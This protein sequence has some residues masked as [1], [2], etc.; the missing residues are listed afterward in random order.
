[1]NRSKENYVEEFLKFKPELK[2]FVFRLMANRQDTEDI[3]HD[4]FLKMDK[5]LD[6]FKGESSFKTWVFSIATNTAK[7]LLKKKKRW[8]ENAPDY[9]AN[10]HLK[11]S[12]H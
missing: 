9:G 1:M 10:L 6:T 12:E 5:G 4:T 3:I 11:S 8:L 7:N 2:S